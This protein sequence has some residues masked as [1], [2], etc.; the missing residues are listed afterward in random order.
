L[1]DKINTLESA[2]DYLSLIQ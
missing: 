2:N 1:G